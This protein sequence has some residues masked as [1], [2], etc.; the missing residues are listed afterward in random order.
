MNYEQIGCFRRVMSLVIILGVGACG[1]P[2]ESTTQVTAETS[3]KDSPSAMFDEYV[4]PRE[5]AGTDVC[6]LL[7]GDAVA[8]ATN[9]Q[10][11]GTK[12]NMDPA[13]CTYT[14]R[15]AEPYDKEIVVGV[16]GNG[17]S[18]TIGRQTAS[19]AEAVPGVGVDSWT[20]KTTDNQ[21]EINVKRED[22]VYIQVIAGDREAALAVAELAID[23]IPK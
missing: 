6:A 9:V 4:K 8:M 2:T 20:K 10:L 21:I 11:V 18:F 19:N 3:S 7:P 14:V 13:W 17:M 12:P 5:F 16:D 1:S 15:G 22:A 23:A